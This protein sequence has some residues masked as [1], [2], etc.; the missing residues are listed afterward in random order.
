MKPLGIPILACVSGLLAGCASFG[1]NVKGDFICRAPDGTCS[2]TSNID[3]QAVAGIRGQQRGAGTP[4]SA[5]ATPG[6]AGATLKVVMPARYDRFGR[7]RDETVVYVEREP[8]A[9]SL[10]EPAQAR[11][12]SSRLTLAELAAGAPEV[13]EI[14]PPP[15]A[16]ADSANA[17]GDP[18][19]RIKAD[20][21]A[22]LNASPRYVSVPVVQG[23]ARSKTGDGAQAAIEPEPVSGVDVSPDGKIIT[24][25]QFPASESGDE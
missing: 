3:D 16:P 9:S 2:P 1:G 21:E 15:R 20:V 17:A 24:A 8:I 13:G 25:P 23:E 4:V 19:A 10:T 14:A 18:V 7:W 5:A 6:P 11:S 22:R 12:A